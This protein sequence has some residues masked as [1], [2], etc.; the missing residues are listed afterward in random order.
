MS[1]KQNFFHLKHQVHPDVTSRLYDYLRDKVYWEDGIRSRRG[2]TRKAAA[3]TA[4]EFRRLLDDFPE[5][6][7]KIDEITSKY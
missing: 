4:D 3:F 2:P 6:L 7:A 5:V 1:Q